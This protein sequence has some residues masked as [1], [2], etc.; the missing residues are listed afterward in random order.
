MVELFKYRRKQLISKD[1]VQIL[2]VK[3]PLEEDEMYTKEMYTSEWPLR[4]RNIKNNTDYSLGDDNTATITVSFSY[5]PGGID[6]LLNT[7][8]C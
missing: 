1:K 6:N 4:L 3:V 5:T 2:S 8:L 7:D